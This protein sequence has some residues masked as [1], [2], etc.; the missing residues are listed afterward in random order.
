MIRSNQPT[1]AGDAAILTA[2]LIRQLRDQNKQ[3]QLAKQKEAQIRQQVLQ[4]L[5]ATGCLNGSA[6]FSPPVR[7]TFQVNPKPAVYFGI[8]DAI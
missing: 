1:F 3:D 5:Q 4:E 2:N 6:R 8:G 7:D